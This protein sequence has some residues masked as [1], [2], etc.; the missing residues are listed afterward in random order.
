MIS[1]LQFRLAP[2]SADETLHCLS[3]LIHSSWSSSVPASDVLASGASYLKKARA[4]TCWFRHSPYTL[5]VAALTASYNSLGLG[6]LKRRLLRECDGRARA[7]TGRG[8]DIVG[9]AAC[10]EAM[11]VDERAVATAAA[12]RAARRGSNE[13][14]VCSNEAPAKEGWGS[15]TGVAQGA[16]ELL[17][18][19]AF[20]AVGGVPLVEDF[21]PAPSPK[22]FTPCAELTTAGLGVDAGC[23]GSSA[24]VRM[25][26]NAPRPR[27]PSPTPIALR[28]Q[29]R[30]GIKRPFH[31]TFGSCFVPC[32]ARSRVEGLIRVHDRSAIRVGHGGVEDRGSGRPCDESNCSRQA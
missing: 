24:S 14:P 20:S 9:V 22:A 23:T 6:Q 2:P 3:T 30:V 1:K 10:V 12:A 19:A 26:A 8:L 11:S 17:R 31:Q 5:A 21:S 15:P 32:A 27:A 18:Q 4:R 28:Q 7:V 25:R 16:A 29:Q 13:S